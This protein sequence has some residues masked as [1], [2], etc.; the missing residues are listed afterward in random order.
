MRLKIAARRPGAAL[1]PANGLNMNVTPKSTL[2]P[3]TGGA[4][5]RKRVED[6]LLEAVSHRPEND[7]PGTVGQPVQPLSARRPVSSTEQVASV[8]FRSGFPNSRPRPGQSHSRSRPG[9]RRPTDR[10]GRRSRRPAV[11]DHPRKAVGRPP[12]PAPR[13][14][15]R[16][17]A[18]TAI[19]RR[20]GSVWTVAGLELGRRLRGRKEVQDASSLGEVPGA[21]QSAGGERAVSWPHV[22]PSR[23]PSSDGHPVRQAERLKVPQGVRTIVDPPSSGTWGS[24]RQPASFQADRSRRSAR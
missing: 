17:P 4:D 9:W 12:G 16:R 18:A 3:T 8:T 19:V 23:R 1:V 20:S 13:L 21:R 10:A 11:G 7:L 2:R 24:G 5:P 22:T 15:S 6:R 14:P